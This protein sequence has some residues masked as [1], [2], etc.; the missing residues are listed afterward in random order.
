MLKKVRAIALSNKDSVY[1]TTVLG[2]GYADRC[3]EGWSDRYLIWAMTGQTDTWILGRYL[4]SIWVSVYNLD[5]ELSRINTL[6]LHLIW[7]KTF[8]ISI[9]WF[10]DLLIQRPKHQNSWSVNWLVDISANPTT[11]WRTRLLGSLKNTPKNRGPPR[12]QVPRY[13]LRE[14]PDR[15]LDS[16]A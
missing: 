6:L 8:Y 5:K 4:G 15:Y 10:T 9:N 11:R 1:I 14:R 7:P 12:I 16:R 13:Y 2:I 3:L